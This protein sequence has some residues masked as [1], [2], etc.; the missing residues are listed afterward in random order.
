M[1]DDVQHEQ[2]PGGGS[3][4]RQKDGSLV[5][6]VEDDAQPKAAEAEAAP[7]AHKTKTTRGK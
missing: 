4:I 2:P 7:H 5:R 6:R 1:S 3:F